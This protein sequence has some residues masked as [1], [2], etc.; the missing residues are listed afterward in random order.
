MKHVRKSLAVLLAVAMLVGAVPAALAAPVEP[1]TDVDTGSWYASAV[2]YVYHHDPRLMTGM[3]GAV[4]VPNGTVSR[5]MVVQ[6]LYNLAGSPKEGGKNPFTDLTKSWYR[7]AVLWGA[8]NQIVAGTSKTTFSP[9]EFVTREQAVSFLWRYAGRPVV[10]DVLANWPDGKEVSSFARGA[11]NWAITVGIVSG[12]YSQEDRA[13]YLAP[14]ATLNRAELARILMTYCKDCEEGKHMWGAWTVVT[15][16]AC[17]E[18]GSQMHTC[19]RCGETQTEAVAALGHDWGEWKTEKD[20]TCTEDGSRTHSCT[21]CGETQTETVA[22]LGHDWGEWKTEKD[23]TCTEDGSRTRSC[24]RCD[25]TE[26]EVLPA[27]GHIDENEDG[28]CDRCKIEL[29][30][31]AKITLVSPNGTEERDE[32]IGEDFAFPGCSWKDD[33]DYTFLGW[34]A[35]DTLYTAEKPDYYKEGDLLNVTKEGATFYALFVVNETG[36][37]TKPTTVYHVKLINLGKEQDNEVG[38]GKTF[39]L[40]DSEWSDPNYIFAGWTDKEVDELPA[41]EFTG[42]TVTAKGTALTVTGDVT[43]YALYG[44]LDGE[45]VAHYTTKPSVSVT[46]HIP[47]ED[48]PTVETVRIGDTYTFTGCTWEDPGYVFVGWVRKDLELASQIDDLEVFHE[49]DTLKIA[50]GETFYAL[51]SSK[52]IQYARPSAEVKDYT[53]D[54]AIVGVGYETTQSGIVA[55]L[56]K[57]VALNDQGER[58]DLETMPGVA[59]SEK[60]NYGFYAFST[61]E[62]SIRFTVSTDLDGAYLIQTQDGAFL[63]WDGSQGVEIKDDLTENAKWTITYE[64]DLNRALVFSAA[65]SKMVLVYNDEQKEFQ[66]LDNTKNTY[67]PLYDRTP[68]EYYQLYLYNAAESPAGAYTTK[69]THSQDKPVPKTT[70][71]VTLSFPENKTQTYHMKPNAKL[72]LP[73]CPWQ[74]S[75][76]QFKGWTTTNQKAITKEE[77]EKLSVHPAGE[78]YTV[79]EA[80]TLYAIFA[81]RSGAASETTGYYYETADQADY[82]GEWAIIGGYSKQYA[83]NNEVGKMDLTKQEDVTYSDNGLSFSTENTTIRFTI[84]PV[85]GEEGYYTIRTQN[86]GYLTGNENSISDTPPTVETALSELAKW[87]IRIDPS[88]YAEIYVK[89]NSKMALCYDFDFTMQYGE[90]FYGGPS[91]NCVYLYKAVKEDVSF[92]HYTT[93]P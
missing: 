92:D 62:T 6:T 73:E 71:D 51:F 16:A 39:T 53:G 80:A 88:G 90:R 20:A 43:Y 25:K 8:E 24:T 5:A 40:P 44:K 72:T 17:T 47:E 59:L 36:Y 46:L 55:G 66:V 50:G 70:V 15:A 49:G 28:F 74:D 89:G 75:S 19:L 63:T 32:P 35:R 45:D 37:T 26:T 4:F 27:L 38:I 14:K 69:P 84:A 2:K 12:R 52:T 54:W 13:S 42:A 60:D 81:E 65:S 61:L 91:N 18:A 21:R 30:P 1:F 9:E 57:P 33:P 31:A 64:P 10:A 68:G 3:S 85:E 41:A 56:G 23:A 67:G 78:A 82:S 93:Q 34:T 29:K 7:S 22:A 77:Y 79:T 48:A 11:M 58:A 83:L 76:H 87:T 86:G